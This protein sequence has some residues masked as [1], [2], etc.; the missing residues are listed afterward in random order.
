MR[1]ILVLGLKGKYFFWKN[2]I[3]LRV[4]E[5][6]GVRQIF[7]FKIRIRYCRKYRHLVL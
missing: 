3:V 6:M 2:K 7:N 4:L 1:Y 5:V